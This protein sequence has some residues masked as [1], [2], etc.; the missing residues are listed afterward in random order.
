M[1]IAALKTAR[2]ISARHLDWSQHGFWPNIAEIDFPP[3]LVRGQDLDAH[4]PMRQPYSSEMSTSML[5][6]EPFYDTWHIQRVTWDIKAQM[7]G[8]WKGLEV[9]AI[10]RGHYDPPQ[11]QQIVA[12]PSENII[13][14]VDREALIGALGYYKI[15]E[16]NVNDG[17]IL[18]QKLHR[19]GFGIGGIFQASNVP[20]TCRVWDCIIRD[21][22][23]IVGPLGSMEHLRLDLDVGPPPGVKAIAPYLPSPRYGAPIF[24]FLLTTGSNDKIPANSSPP[25]ARRN[26]E[27]LAANHVAWMT[28][29]TPHESLPVR[30]RV[31]RQYF[32][33]VTSQVTTWYEAHSTRND[34]CGIMPPMTVA[35]VRR[36]KFHAAGVDDPPA[37]ALS[38]VPPTA[39]TTV[40]AA[41]RAAAAAFTGDAKAAFRWVSGGGGDN[42]LVGIRNGRRPTK[43][44]WG[45]HDTAAPD[46]ESNID[47]EDNGID[48]VWPA[49]KRRATDS[50]VPDHQYQLHHQQQHHIQIRD[51][52]AHHV[53]IHDHNTLSPDHQHGEVLAASASATAAAANGDATAYIL[54]RA[55]AQSSVW[56]QQKQQLQQ[57]HPELLTPESAFIA[58]GLLRPELAEWRA[59]LAAA[60]ARAALHTRSLLPPLP[61]EQQQPPDEAHAAALHVARVA[62]A[63]L[64]TGGG[65]LEE[66]WMRGAAAAAR[67]Q[68]ADELRAGPA[69]PKRPPR[70]LALAHYL[71]LFRVVLVGLA[72]VGLGM[73]GGGGEGDGGFG[74]IVAA[75]EWLSA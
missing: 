68:Q 25:P 19:W 41:A 58:N 31:F 24:P 46:D 11:D 13:G 12:Q 36:N 49:A 21:H 53:P 67:A 27:N 15:N 48:T 59:T 2:D 29:R 47:G 39:P 43:R 7:Q 74:A 32:R 72:A 8:L 69:S 18:T 16:G 63:L 50:L 62:D 28:D 5:T 4:V 42:N 75:W 44:S 37:L 40:Q 60:A 1:V 9:W 51:T 70:V 23:D 55:L 66:L 64:A 30:R 6:A 20:D 22:G 65:G 61:P 54:W 71:R 10:E 26:G 35:I 52:P 45:N 38:V 73:G 33:L 57:H 56:L 3:P 34:E 14:E 17:G